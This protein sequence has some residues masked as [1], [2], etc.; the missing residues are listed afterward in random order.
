MDESKTGEV[1]TNRPEG[2]V[3]LPDASPKELDLSNFLYEAIDASDFLGVSKWAQY[4]DLIPVDPYIKEGYRYKA[5]AWFRV[6]HDKAKAIEGID[7]HI[8]AVNKLSGMDDEQ[9][10]KY[11]ST[12]TP[13][14]Q[15]K[16]TGYS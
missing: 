9:G 6:K 8:A 10:K 4:F 1:N 7:Q 15:S 11:L 14:W 2:A 16:N 5:I 13:S 12:G 3:V